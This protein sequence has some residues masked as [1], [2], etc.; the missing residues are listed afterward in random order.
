MLFDVNI[1]KRGFVLPR[2]F[3]KDFGHLDAAHVVYEGPFDKQLI[4]DV[5]ENKFD[6]KEGIVAKGV[7]GNSVHDLWMTKVKT[8]WWMDE[9]RRRAKE[10]VEL[11]Q[12]L[13]E[14]EREQHERT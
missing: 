13:E 10:Q 5:K 9:L 1:H 12:L 2:Q 3:V 8:N 7:S 4:Q 6:L 11:R 14:N